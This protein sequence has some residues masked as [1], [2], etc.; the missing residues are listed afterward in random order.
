MLIL[1]FTYIHP[2]VYA[3]TFEVSLSIYSRYHTAGLGTREC[4]CS[5]R[6][7]EERVI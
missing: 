2:Y 3:R 7:G 5:E 1:F 4:V 6:F